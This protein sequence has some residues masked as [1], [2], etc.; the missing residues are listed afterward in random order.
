MQLCLKT[1]FHLLTI[2]L[3]C[4]IDPFSFVLVISMCEILQRRCLQSQC[5]IVVRKSWLISAC[6]RYRQT[7]D[8]DTHITNWHMYF[9]LFSSVSF[10]GFL[11]Y[12]TFPSSLFSLPLCLLSLVWG[13]GVGSGQAPVCPGHLSGCDGSG[14]PAPPGG[15]PGSCRPGSWSCDKQTTGPLADQS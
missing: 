15:Q 11:L 4:K 10:S 13:W 6:N 9:H 3:T 8:V 1:N 12:P 2:G 5:A 7:H 14:V